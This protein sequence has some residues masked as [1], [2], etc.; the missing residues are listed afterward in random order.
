MLVCSGGGLS[1]D[2][3]LNI[4]CGY[5][6]NTEATTWQ[7]QTQTAVEALRVA[8][9]LELPFAESLTDKLGHEALKPLSG[10]LVREDGEILER[11]ACGLLELAIRLQHSYSHRQADIQQQRPQTCFPLPGRGRPA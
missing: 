1:A 11:E 4:Y 10:I 7:K 9:D 5:T 6:H 8:R 3:S 2:L